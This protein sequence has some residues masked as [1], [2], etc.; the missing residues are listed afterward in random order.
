MKK[1]LVFLFAVLLVLSISDLA[2]A[3]VYFY[4]DFETSWS[5]DY[6]PGW[7]GAGYRHGVAPVAKMQQSTTGYGGSSYGLKLTADSTPLTTQWWA[8]VEAQSLPSWVMAKE[9]D[10]YVKAMYYDDQI[11][12]RT[13]QIYTVPSWVNPYIPPGEDW[14]DIQFGARFNQ[15]TT[16]NYFYV[17][18]GQNSP[19]WQ[20]TGK[21]RSAGWHELKLQL[22][23]T[24]GK[25][26]F[27]VDGSAVGTSFRSDYNDL[28][29]VI[30]LYTMF[31]NPLTNWG[32]NKPYTLWDNFEVGSTAVPEPAT[33]LLLGFGLV[34]I[35]G[36]RRKFRN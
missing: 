2:S 12:G 9:Y 25:I 10:P 20:D 33:M 32:D 22:S 35:A 8:A 24:D 4:D 5:G 13:G 19:G 16:A 23:N 18:A 1:I 3:T 30:G 21:A 31:Q 15:P 17:A 34:G 26:H 36:I 11:A 27:Y 14:T 29:D 28:G 7:V 6:A